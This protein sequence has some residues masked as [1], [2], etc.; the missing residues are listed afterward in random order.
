M[1]DVDSDA[2]ILSGGR[3]QYKP[4]SHPSLN[5]EPIVTFLSLLLITK[6][7]IT[8]LLVALP[9]LLGPQA[10]LEAAT[11][12]SA[13]RPIFFRLYGVAITALLVGYGFGI[14][15]AEHQQLPWGVVMMGLVSNTGAALLLLSSAKPRSMN[16]WLGSFFALIALALAASAVAPGLALSKA[17]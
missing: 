6:I 15:S 14:P 7:A 8:A 12:L 3:L 17:W 10:R 2:G 11:G 1:K 9:F 16:F 4:T 13:K 5:R